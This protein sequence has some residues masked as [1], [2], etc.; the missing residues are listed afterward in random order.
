MWSWRS[1]RID[2]AAPAGPTR[3]SI[4]ARLACVDVPYLALQIVLRRHPEWADL[5]VAVV[6]HDR[7]QGI[8]LATNRAARAQRVLPGMRYAAGL[9]LARDLRA[10]TVEPAEITG[11]VDELLAA[12][13]RFSPEVEPRAEPPGIFWMR[14]G[15]LDRLFGS[16]QAWG[17]AL[18]EA[19]A[20]D[21]WHGSVVV[22]FTRFGTYAL[23]R[24]SRPGTVHLLD[25]AR[26][27][28]DLHRRVALS[29]L[30]IPPKTRDELARLGVTTVGAFLDLPEGGVRRRFGDDAYR[31]H[32]LARG[33]LALPMQAKAPDE[34]IARTLRL[35]HPE[36]NAHRL[37]FGIKAELHTM[38][39][40]LASRFE[41]LARLFLE[42]HLEGGDLI[43]HELRPA[44]PTLDE[45]RL[46]ELLRL[47]LDRLVLSAGVVAI[48]LTA[49]GA[50]TEAEQSRLLASARRYSVD[51]ANYALAR[52]RA[53]F[54]ER[55][56]LGVK[57]RDA[58]LPEGQFSL[59]PLERLRA[60]KPSDTT[61][62][63]LIRRI[64][65]R[66]E[67]LPRFDPEPEPGW[68]IRGLDEGPVVRTDGPYRLC[69]G[70]WA[71]AIRRDYYFAHTRRGDIYWLY[72][73]HRRRQ[74]FVQGTVE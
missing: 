18:L 9:S 25:D 51:D 32:R 23:A 1:S 72:F 13:H 54:G 42:L 15:G 12:L 56:V 45:A 28:Q 14:V 46:L 67:P 19:L 47:Y 70:W 26:S 35:D 68:L 7:P 64:L 63:T 17:D 41:A 65:V 50:S 40:A 48:E 27:E 36:T 44:R 55:A 49:E 59:E 60:P 2:A 71:R 21:G 34:P 8:L 43:E 20:D 73:D 16:F 4:V 74:W 53:E 62:A 6:D 39:M 38:R 5:P 24:A 22:G 57:L 11:A 30:D 69:G 37:L 3:G 10:A 31:L 29:T 66:P 52:L 61:E 33:Q 58:H